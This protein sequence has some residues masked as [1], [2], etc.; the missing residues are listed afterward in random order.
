MFPLNDRFTTKADKAFHDSKWDGL[1]F[2]GVNFKYQPPVDNLPEYLKWAITLANVITTSGPGTGQEADISK[3][4]TFRKLLG[5]HSLALA[6][7]VTVDNIYS[8]LPYVDAYL[9]GTGI[10]DS[11]GVLN[12]N[13]TKELAERI[14]SYA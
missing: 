5:E 14:H 9:V 6:S 11:F 8:Y 13:K 4:R 7:G 3:I 10:E 12:P 2:A 1:F